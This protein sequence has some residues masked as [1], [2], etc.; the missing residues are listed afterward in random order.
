MSKE[1]SPYAKFELYK[2]WLEGYKKK[3]GKVKDEPWYS[4]PI[5]HG[6][7]RWVIV[8]KGER[9]IIT[10]DYGSS[11]KQYII[12]P[13]A[14][15]EISS[16]GT[17][18]NVYYDMNNFTTNKTYVYEYNEPDKRREREFFKRNRYDG[19][20][21]KDISVED[22]IVTAIALGAFN[23]DDCDFNDYD[24]VDVSTSD[25]DS[26]D[27]DTSDFDDYDSSGFD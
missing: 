3:G 13:G 1:Y 21:P 12:M 2:M 15:L 18:H 5:F 11:S 6:D 4:R 7:E 9:C 27:F 20:Y 25:F 24:S 16:S 26:S 17:G 10:P 19:I 8:E 23:S 22:I 14:E